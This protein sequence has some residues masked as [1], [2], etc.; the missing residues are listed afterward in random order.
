MRKKTILLTLILAVL[1]VFSL[2]SQGP[3]PF[4]A[5]NGMVST[6]HPLASEA[7]L[8]ILQA[9]GNAVDA[10]VAA[11]FAIGVVEP[12][13]SGIG[14]GGGMVVYLNDVKESY[15]INYYGY[16]SENAVSL[17]FN[18]TRDRASGKSV[19]VPGTVGGLLAAHSKFGSLPLATVM[20]P[21]IEYASKGFRIDNTLAR[22]ILD[23]IEVVMSDPAT[24]AVFLEDGFP[25][26]EGDL[27]VQ[28]ELAEVLREI[29]LRGRAAFYEGKYAEA[30]VRGLG[31]RGGVLTLEDFAL[32]D[33]VIT[34][35]LKG[36]YRGYDVLSTALPQGGS[37][38][39]LGLNILENWDFS[40]SA[41][42]SK[43]AETFQVIAETQKLITADRYAY[44]ADPMMVD[45]PVKGLLSKE[46]ALSR[47]R[48]ISMD[49]LDPPTYRQTPAGKPFD[50]NNDNPEESES[51]EADIQGHTTTLSVIDKDGNA[52]ALTQTLGLFFGSG[53]TVSGVLFNCAM[54][55]YSYTSNNV[56]LI[57]NR[58]QCR[59]TITPAI[60]LKNGNPFL[61]VGS[62][63]SARITSTVMEL[64]IN[65]IDFGMNVEEAN[66][67]PRFYC[68]KMEDFLH[69]EAGIDPAVL[70]KLEGM[71]HKLKVYD[72]IDLFFGGAQMIMVD[73]VTG[74][75][76]GSADKR[77]GGEVKGY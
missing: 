11:A 46:Y 2:Q 36:T 14:G 67:A 58:K 68:Q 44:I 74:I 60:V 45:V 5:R 13:G 42:F 33:P 27:L 8:K 71:G 49:K 70:L 3:V 76:Y 75:Y 18:S 6:A 72:D 48:D 19:G 69:I 25:K 64:I 65:I 4:S 23:N 20:A 41:H 55:N 63:G 28:A 15:Y 30:F 32:Y 37:T 77:R 35:P 7:A 24:A 53:Q 43:S 10:A 57:D 73:P 52:V 40:K 26:M 1:T 66:I 31:E 12:D 21:A 61:I 17:N 51:I 16:S 22:L 59:S 47:F 38:L 62:P 34:S 39:I 56:N 54:T 29:S 50:Y 9:G